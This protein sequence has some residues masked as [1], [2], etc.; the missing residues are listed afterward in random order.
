[1]GLFSLRASYQNFAAQ[2]SNCFYHRGNLSGHMCE[3]A[4]LFL[5]GR[6]RRS[7]CVYANAQGVALIHTAAEKHA[8]C[9]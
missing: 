4:Q 6:R 2:V 8:R 5:Q 7:A 1:M 3:R 9:L